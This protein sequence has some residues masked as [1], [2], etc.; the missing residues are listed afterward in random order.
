MESKKEI[1]IPRRAIACRQAGA[2]LKREQY[3]SPFQVVPYWKPEYG[4]SVVPE[5]GCAATDGPL[6]ALS[7]GGPATLQE[8]LFVS[9]PTSLFAAID[10]AQRPLVGLV[11]FNST[12]PVFNWAALWDYPGLFQKADIP[13]VYVY[14]AESH[15]LDGDPAPTGMTP[16]LKMPATLEQRFRA[17]ETYGVR[18]LAKALE[19]PTTRPASLNRPVGDLQFYVWC[20]GG[21]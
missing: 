9:Q 1:Q 10:A 7:V 6:H 12:C 20:L 5:E 8:K 4:P 21:G 14:L 13:V 11:F 17:C 19:V 16:P 3:E 18:M 2:V 15:T